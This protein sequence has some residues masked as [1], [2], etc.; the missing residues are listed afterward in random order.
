MAQRRKY[1]HM[2]MVVEALLAWWPSA[3]PD[4]KYLPGK[5]GSLKILLTYKFQNIFYDSDTQV[6]ARLFEY[7]SS[8]LLEQHIL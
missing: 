6:F 8:S 4:D 7:L 1:K 2:T 3:I 5:S